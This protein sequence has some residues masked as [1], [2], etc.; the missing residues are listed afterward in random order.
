MKNEITIRTTINAPVSLVWKCWTTP[1]DIMNWNN[2]SADWH[3]THAKNDLREGGQFFSRMESLDKKEGFDFIGTYDVVIPFSEI[4]YRL[5]DNRKVSILFSSAKEGITVTETF[6]TENTFPVEKQREGWQAILDNFKKYV[7]SR[8]NSPAFTAIKPCLWFDYQAEEAVKFYTSIFP[9]SE[10]GE[11]V[12]YGKA[13]HDIHKQEEGKIQTIEF[14]MNGQWYTALNGGPIFHFN[15]AISLQILCDT[16]KEIDY[17]WE[18]LTADGEEGPCGWLKDKFGLSWQV[19]PSIL[20]ELL[21]DPERA[22]RVTDVY[23]KM[24]KF[25]INKLLQA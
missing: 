16:Q 7:E 10:I 9:N 12:R 18:K 13:G 24:K 14:K 5:E 1:A 17:Y 20:P 2:A 25:D 6:D 15:E 3:T 4:K 11:I 19:A 21:K 8:K 23:M 22:E